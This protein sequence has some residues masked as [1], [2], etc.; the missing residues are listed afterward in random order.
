MQKWWKRS[1][2]YQIYPRSFQDSNGDGI[3]DING[4]TSRLDYLKELGVE[5]LWLSPIYRS[6]GKDNGYDIADY[7]DIEPEFGTMED[8]ENLLAEAHQRGLKIVM[9]LVVNHTSDQ[10]Q[11]FIESRSSCDNPYRDFYIWHEGEPETPPNNWGS[12]F[13]GSAW[14]WDERTQMYYLHL[15]AVGQPDLNWENPVMRQAV[16]EMM[17]WWCDKGIDGF[18]MDVINAISKELNFPDGEVRNGCYGNADPYVINGPRVEEHLRE[19]RRKVLDQYDLFTV[20]ETPSVTTEQAAA[21]SNLDGSELDMVFQ[22]EH[23]G[24]DDGELGKWTLRRCNMPLLRANLSKWQIELEGRGWNSLYWDNH[25]QP[26][27]VSRFGDDRPEFRERSAKML[28]TCLHM[29]KGTPFVYQGEELGMTNAYFTALEDY[30]DVEGLGFYRQYTEAGV[31]SAEEMMQCLM[32]RGRDNARTPMPWS[33]AS[34]AGFTEGK[35]W[36]KVNANY[37]EINARQQLNDPDSVFHYY[38]RL[39]ALRRTMPVMVEGIYELLLPDDENVWAY[40]RTLGN[41]KLLVLLNFCDH[42]VRCE[43]QIPTQ[44]DIVIGNYKQP[45]AGILHPYEAVVY[46]LG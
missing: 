11:W 9:D 37:K 16:Y 35:P 40:T 6:G 25:D 33:D 41:D 20:G 8:F 21:Y 14:Q 38:Q 29:M 5:I 19:M 18:R 24:L 7:Y 45:Q 17:S 46:K 34:N 39:I 28:A 4:I 32:A 13:G 12:N 36:I 26:R 31:I 42:D 30:R 22:F 15:F 10:H 23:V 2:V 3:G 43:L 27:A 1:V 44:G